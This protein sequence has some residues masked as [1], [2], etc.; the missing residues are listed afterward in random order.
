MQVSEGISRKGISVIAFWFMAIL[1]VI[2]DQ[3]TKVAVRHLMPVGSP[4]RPL[5]P[6]VIDL[7]RVENTGAAF[8][9]GRGSTW[10]FVACAAV[11]FLV[12]CYMVW[13]YE[14]PF[15]LVLSLGCV[16]GGGVGNMID[17]IATGSVTDFLAT[18][19]I[20]FPVFNVADIFV[21]CGVA[22]SVVLYLRWEA[23]QALRRDA[24]SKD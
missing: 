6:G 14:L 23:E 13:H 4:P 10:L 9:I 18:T 15:P 24:D 8:S 19:F 16:A 5:I 11:A 17:R 12:A 7:Y 3:A 1:V 21:T 22:V 2:A 20:N